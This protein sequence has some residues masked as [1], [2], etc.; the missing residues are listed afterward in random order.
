MF[1]SS[2]PL[3]R[4][5]AITAFLAGS[6]ATAWGA[7]EYV[8]PSPGERD[9]VAALVAKGALVRVDGTYRASHVV[10]TTNCTND[11]LKLLAA[12]EK[13]TG[14]Q[15]SSRNI[16][17]AGIEHLKALPK[18]TS[19]T[20]SSSGLTDA[21]IAALRTG[22]PKARI[23]KLATVGASPSGSSS[24]VTSGSKGI[25]TNAPVRGVAA[26]EVGVKLIESGAT[27]KIGGYMPLR[28]EMTGNA[29]SVKKAPEGLAAPKYGTLKL[30]TQSW[31]FI[32]DEPDGKPAKLYVDTNSDGDLTNDSATAWSSRKIEN[33]EQY[34]GTARVDLADGKRGAINLYRFDPSDSRRA[35]LKNTMMFY[36]D[37]GYELTLTLDGNSFTTVVGAEAGPMPIWIDRDNNSVRSSKF[38]TIRFGTPFNFTGTT[39]V[40]NRDGPEFKLEKAATPLPVAPLPPNLAVGQKAIPFQTATLDGAKIDFPK[41]YAGKLVLLDFWATW[42]GPCI[43]E[44]PN[45]KKAYTDW[46]DK[47]FEILGISFDNANMADKVKDFLQEHDLPWPQVYEGKGW[48][49][50]LG[51]QYDV[52]AIPFVLLVDGDSGEILAT[53]YELRGTGLSEF[54]GAQL[55]KKKG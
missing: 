18:V 51:E 31:I 29:A 1:S 6:G 4:I 41:M 50:T 39:Y 27:A 47:G 16:T 15:V 21:G 28:A 7:E 48:T 53:A 26:D 32:L 25:S 8:A 34:S 35:S 9:A 17:D 42:C 46:H 13:L 33:F 54:I 14:L 5:V 30:G 19:I 10:L 36:P 55:A 23:T 52:H 12:C 40:L 44:L 43:A 45:V 11:D 38:E 2:F 24:A 20:V 37:F 49:T 3:S 22:L